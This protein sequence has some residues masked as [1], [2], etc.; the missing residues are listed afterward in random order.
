MIG[1]LK[2]ERPLFAAL[3]ALLFFLPFLAMPFGGGVMGLVIS[4]ASF[5]LIY[6]IAAQA[7]NLQVGYTG[8]LNL[9]LVAFVGIGGYTTAI[10]LSVPAG[11]TD[12]L[13]AVRYQS[14]SGRA[15]SIGR[16]GRLL[17][18]D[19]ESGARLASFATTREPLSAMTEG[20]DGRVYVGTAKGRVLVWSSTDQDVIGRY[21]VSEKAKKVTALA[22][23]GERLLVGLESGKVYD[24]KAADGSGATS[25]QAH[26]LPIACLR[27]LSDGRILTTG[28]DKQLKIWSAPGKG[29]GASASKP[30]MAWKK[31]PGRVMAL[32]MTGGDRT[33][34][35]GLSDNSIVLADLETQ[36]IL[37]TY[38]HHARSI[39]DLELLPDGRFLAASRDKT[40]SLWKRNES[41]P[42][43]VFKG[44]LEA[45]R[46]ISVAAD[47]ETFV[48]A[49]EDK[50]A[51]LWT[52]AD[53]TAQRLPV[54]KWALVA[55]Y[56]RVLPELSGGTQ[57]AL[58]LLDPHF[59]AYM[60]VTIP[61]M[62]AAA[63]LSLLIGI[64][65]LR[66]RGDYFAIV[67]LGF[68]Q[69]LLLIVR[70]EEWLTSGPSGIKNLP[71]LFSFSSESEFAL[72]TGHYYLGL[73]F[74]AIS[75]VVMMR[76]RDSRIGRAFMAIRDDELAAQSNGIHLS[77]YKIYSFLV[78]SMVAALAG[79]VQVS[80]LR[81]ISPNDLLFWESILYLCCVVLGGLGSV[82]GAVLGA[83][84]L[85]S[86]GEVMRIG[87]SRLPPNWA[88]PAQVRYIMFGVILILVM[89]FRPQGLFPASDEE[90]DRGELEKHRH[91][92][93]EASLFK[94]GRDD[95][96]AA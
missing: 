61:A 69:I 33:A 94:I 73:F 36:R 50:L 12:D 44:H 18:W 67:T 8:L 2:N 81:I 30:S 60:T 53:G 29:Q 45:V 82:R 14:K 32:A 56:K 85:G 23:R 21:E 42:E 10:L 6:L 22:V 9:G 78:A 24:V 57:K 52:I 39:T 4:V 40:V 17:V 41:K 46:D 77:K 19:A 16:D 76:L 71:T 64:P 37:R 26:W 38:K 93:V 70:N 1:P 54:A 31:M 48:S 90:L 74:F 55:F 66:L 43:R 87:I 51:Q 25:F 35:L 13:A 28:R 63:L 11:H 88:I 15:I 92:D 86:L 47:G 95:A 59:L 89:R 34:L 27:V 68:A 3:I 72:R 20:P 75:L 58:F 84:I 49:G 7:L 5:T 96:G 80:R 65:T 83:V 91:R 62:L 79:V